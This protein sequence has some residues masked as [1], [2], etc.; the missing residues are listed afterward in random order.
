MIPS[1]TAI[2]IAVILASAGL[3]F[4]AE[5]EQ[6]RQWGFTGGASCSDCET[7]NDVLKDAELYKISAEQADGYLGSRQILKFSELFSAG[8]FLWSLSTTVNI[9]TSAALT[10]GAAENCRPYPEIKKFLANHADKF[11]TLESVVKENNMAHLK[12]TR[13]DGS[14]E[15]VRIESWNSKAILDFVEEHLEKEK[16]A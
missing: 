11:P 16:K 13:A 6:C 8:Y 1:I 10:C 5:T 3:A 4:S 7:L 2:Q 15:I 14:S 9:E 12:L